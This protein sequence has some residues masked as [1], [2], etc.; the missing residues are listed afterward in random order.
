MYEKNIIYYRFAQSIACW[1][2]CWK[3]LTKPTDYFTQ[4]MHMDLNL[5]MNHK[6][7]DSTR[8]DRREGLSN[9]S[10]YLLGKERYKSGHLLL[11][12]EQQ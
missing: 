4:N 10:L 3:A 9:T 1:K 11:S 2:A 7:L 6:Y 8:Q 5:D 12:P